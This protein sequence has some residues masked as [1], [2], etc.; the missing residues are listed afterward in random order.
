MGQVATGGTVIVCGGTYAEGVSVMK[1]LTIQGTSKATID[2]TNQNNGVAVR[3]SHVTIS[4][5]TVRN[6]TGEGILVDTAN[7]ATIENNVVEHN[8]LGGLPVN[9]VPNNY[10]ECAATEGVPGDCGEGIH[11]MGSSND[12]VRNNVS[13]DN[14]GGILVSDDTGPTAHNRLIGNTVANN[15]LDCGVTIVAHSPK[16]APNGVRNP[17]VAG[18][19]DNEIAG[20]N[21]YGNGTQGDGAGVLLATPVP[22]G[23]DYNNTIEANNIHGNGQSGVTV[24]SHV[25][26]QDLKGNVVR[27]NL[28]GTNNLDGD[29]GFMPAD[30]QT[31]GVLVG[32]S[33]PLSIQVIGN[34]ITNDH[35]GI[36]TVGPV[37]VQNQHLNILHGVTVPF[38]AN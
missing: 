21:V 5:L 27:A 15:V 12:T 6:S 29:S 10:A 22:G 16:G 36:W 13:T 25:P 30:T 34:I 11:L 20:N 14:S 19:F 32:T 3:A 31:T 2:G 24:H 9:P 33:A 28:I 1:S 18:V 26:G 7:N 17:S 8:D 4:G 38:S 37:T 23:A 35:F